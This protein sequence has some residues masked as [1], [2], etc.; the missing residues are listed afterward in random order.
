MKKSI[1]ISQHIVTTEG[2]LLYNCFMEKKFT[3]KSNEDYLEAIY[4][5]ELQNNGEAIRSTVL[6][7]EFEVSKA[8]INKATNELKEKGFIDKTDYSKISLTDK[9]RKV[10]QNIL[11]KHKVI[12]EFLM[13][14]GV[15]KEIAE[16][17]CCLIDHVVS[18]DTVKK[19]DKTL[20]RKEK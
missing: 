18:D 15:S 4:V 11:H 16:K 13:S 10:A 12:M 14:I 8:A 20:S 1:E 19:I 9:G 17:E 7:K 3:T 5:F 6:S 2:Q